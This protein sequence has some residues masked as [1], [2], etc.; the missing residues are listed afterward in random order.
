L[1]EQQELEIQKDTQEEEPFPTMPTYSYSFGGLK[2]DFDDDKPDQNTDFTVSVVISKSDCPAPGSDDEWK[3]IESLC[4]NQ[5]VKYKLPGTSMKII[6]RLLQSRGIMDIIAGTETS[7]NK[8]DM[9][10]TFTVVFLEDK[11]LKRV[12]LS[13]NFDNSNIR[14]VNLLTGFRKV[15]VED[16][17][18][19]CSW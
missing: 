2:I 5:Y 7:L 15:S 13:M 17:A 1:P 11:T 16:V 18:L 3:L 14:S 12:K 4:K 10:E 6:E 9:K 8:Y 19:S